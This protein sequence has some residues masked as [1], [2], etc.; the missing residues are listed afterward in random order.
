MLDALSQHKKQQ[1]ILHPLFLIVLG[2]LE[3]QCCP[4]SIAYAYL[5]TQGHLHVPWVLYTV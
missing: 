3:F 5:P 1:L 2:V 4:P